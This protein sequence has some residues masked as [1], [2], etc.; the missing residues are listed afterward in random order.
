MK[1]RLQYYWL[2]GL[3]F[4]KEQDR[5]K[6]EIELKGVRGTNH[7]GED[8]DNRKLIKVISQRKTNGRE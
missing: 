2:T 1:R 4:V 3:K 7:H 5:L 8:T 6:V